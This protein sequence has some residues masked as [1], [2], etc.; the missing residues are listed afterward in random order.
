MT[1]THAAAILFA[2]AGLFTAIAAAF[3]WWKASGGKPASG[4]GQKADKQSPTGGKGACPG[5]AA[6]YDYLLLRRLRSSLSY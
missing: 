3:Y 4:S 5:G 2:L 6:A 1:L